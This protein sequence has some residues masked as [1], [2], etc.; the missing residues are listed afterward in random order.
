MR[1]EPVDDRDGAAARA[2][3]HHLDHGDAQRQPAA[4]EEAMRARHLEGPRRLRLGVV[5]QADLG[6]GAAH[7]EGEHAVEPA[8]PRHV[9]GEDGAAHRPG[10]DEADGEADRRPDI[11]DA[12]ARQHDVERADEACVPQV[13][14]QLA[15]VARHDRLDVGVGAGGGEA[16]VFAH[17]RRHLG[18]Q[19]D[20]E[21]GQRFPA[22]CRARGAH[23]WG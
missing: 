19:R 21:L 16:L 11:G 20:R 5:D 4:L 3:L 18:R 13:R 9:A 22:G 7:V 6:G 23:A 14:L 15:Q 17:L 2:D 10:F 1:P 8:L 12:A